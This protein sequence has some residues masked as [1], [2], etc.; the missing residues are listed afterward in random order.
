MRNLRHRLPSDRGFTLVAVMGTM[1]ILTV[2]L[3]AS[4]GFAMTNMAPNRKDQDSK[5]AMAAAQA[6]IDDFVSRLNGNDSYWVNN[7]SDKFAASGDTS[8]AAF[9]ATGVSIPGTA[10]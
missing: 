4:L 1:A 3:L 6:G 2:F 10:S 7:S 9:A 5:A 8:N